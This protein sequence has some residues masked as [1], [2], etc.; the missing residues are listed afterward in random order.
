MCVCMLEREQDF[1]VRVREREQGSFGMCTCQ[2][3]REQGFVYVQEHVQVSTCKSRVLC[4]Q[5]RRAMSYMFMYEK[6]RS[7]ACFCT[8]MRVRLPVKS[9]VG[10]FCY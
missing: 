2:S 7:R 4:M 10:F 3:E 6:A 1:C 8:C 5:V 9:S